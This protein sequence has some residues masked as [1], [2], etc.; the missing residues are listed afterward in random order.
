MS[1]K[2]KTNMRTKIMINNYIIEK[3]NSSDYIGYRI[4]V[5]NNRDLEINMI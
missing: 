3:V 2:G 5:S 1:V 4:T